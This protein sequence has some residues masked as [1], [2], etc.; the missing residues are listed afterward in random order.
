MNHPDHNSPEEVEDACLS[1]CL[2]P[3]ENQ[4][5]KTYPNPFDTNLF[6]ELPH[7]E[8]ISFKLFN[9]IGLFVQEGIINTR[10]INLSELPAGIYFIE[11][12]GELQKII[13]L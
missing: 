8:I 6:I 1:S 9:A 12:E 13:K 11:I 7:Q 2:L 3:G 4:V 10:K 5:F